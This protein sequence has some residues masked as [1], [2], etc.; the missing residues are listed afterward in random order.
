MDGIMKVDY[1]RIFSPGFEKQV[2]SWW[3]ERLFADNCGL[4]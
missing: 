2:W 1:K 3:R 4:G